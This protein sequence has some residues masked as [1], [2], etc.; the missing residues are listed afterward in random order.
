MNNGEM[1]KTRYKFSLIK[2][3]S[4]VTVRVNECL[5]TTLQ[6]KTYT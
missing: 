6:I 3:A 4:T 2:L 1:V 5:L